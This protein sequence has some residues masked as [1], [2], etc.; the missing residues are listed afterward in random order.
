MLLYC[1]V[2][3]PEVNYFP[4]QYVLKCVIA[5]TAQQGIFKLFLHHV[6]LS[7]KIIVGIL[8]RLIRYEREQFTQTQNQAL[9]ILNDPRGISFTQSK[10]LL[11]RVHVKLHPQHTNSWVTMATA[12][13]LCDTVVKAQHGE[14]Y[15]LI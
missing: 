1:G 14:D 15:L 11:N 6:T 5:L 12:T 2:K 8:D 13:R 9:I 7:V 3:T 4:K 10:N